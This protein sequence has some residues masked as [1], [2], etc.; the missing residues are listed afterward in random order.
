MVLWRTPK[1]ISIS[2]EISPHHPVLSSASSGF[3]DDD[4]LHCD[5]SQGLS[6]EQFIV[7]M[8]RK[9]RPG[10]IAE[11]LEIKTRAPDGTFNDA[12]LVIVAN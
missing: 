5:S 1:F 4:S 7:D 8:Q 9:G 2:G 11:Y 6:I 12:K 10:L 3:S